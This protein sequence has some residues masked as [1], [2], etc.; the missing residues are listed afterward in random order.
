MATANSVPSPSMNSA[1]S[2][3][4]LCRIHPE[5]PK[6]RIR[7]SKGIDGLRPSMP[8]LRLILFLGFSGWIRHKNAFDFAEFIDGDGTEFAVAIAAGLHATERQMNFGAGCGG[9]DID[10]AGLD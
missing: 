3:A 1:K 5:N 8:L 6:N 7:R 4:F 2:K 9:V 10:Q